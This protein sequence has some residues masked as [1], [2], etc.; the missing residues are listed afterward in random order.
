MKEY[1]N[2]SDT[3]LTLYFIVRKTYPRGGCRAVPD[4]VPP[5]AASHF[6]FAQGLY[7]ERCGDAM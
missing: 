5:A 3:L 6:R 7:A 1:V 4:D 2:E